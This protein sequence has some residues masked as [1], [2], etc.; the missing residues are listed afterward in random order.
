V[1]GERQRRRATRW[2]GRRWSEAEGISYTVKPFDST[3][4]GI[5]QRGEAQ[6]TFLSRLSKSG[7]NNGLHGGGDLGF[8][9]RSILVHCPTSGRIPG[10][11]PLRFSLEMRHIN[12]LR[13]PDK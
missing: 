13:K 6:G 10:Y 7:R 8:W 3:G 12:G 9:W 4:K 1:R 2:G 11:S 5:Q